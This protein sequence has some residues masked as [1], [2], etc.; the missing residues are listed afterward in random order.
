MG[1][2][3]TLPAI[4]DDDGGCVTEGGECKPDPENLCH[5]EVQLEITGGGSLSRFVSDASGCAEWGDLTAAQKKLIAK[6]TT[7]DDAERQDQI[8]GYNNTTCTLGTM[9]GP[10]KVVVWAKC[11]LCVD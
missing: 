3:R 10:E 4:T 5:S 6:S 7:C 9:A 2:F 11:T 8:V 1:S